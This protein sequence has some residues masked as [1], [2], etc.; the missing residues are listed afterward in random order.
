MWSP[1]TAVLPERLALGAPPEVT[2]EDVA[3]YVDTSSPP[4]FLGGGWRCAWTVLDQPDLTPLVL[5]AP[6]MDRA[7]DPN[8]EVTW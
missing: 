7:L 6:V 2:A 8:R 1:V 5:P 4:E 3:A